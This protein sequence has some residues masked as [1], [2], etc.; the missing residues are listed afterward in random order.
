MSQPT[1]L[2]TRTKELALR[3]NSNLHSVCKKRQKTQKLGRL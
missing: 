1:D 2:K 3:V